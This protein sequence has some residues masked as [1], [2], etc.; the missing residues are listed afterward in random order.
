MN[1]SEAVRIISKCA[2]IYKKRL[3]GYQIVFVYRDE[4]NHS[5]YMEVKFRSYNFLHFTGVIPRN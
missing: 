4:N 1:K 3:D 2:N 5:N